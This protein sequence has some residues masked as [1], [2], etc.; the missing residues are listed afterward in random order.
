V[1]FHVDHKTPLT[2]GGNNSPENLCCACPSCNFRKGTKTA[3][4]FIELRAEMG[5]LRQ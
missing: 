1:R 5:R 4:E 2:R 3:E